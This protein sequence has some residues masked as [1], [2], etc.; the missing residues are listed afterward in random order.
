M[1]CF[2]LAE[3]GSRLRGIRHFQKYFGVFLCE[4]ILRGIGQ[5]SGL[6]AGDIR[7]TQELEHLKQRLAVMAEGHRALVGIALLHQHMAGGIDLPELLISLLQ[8]HT[9]RIRLRLLL[10]EGLLDE[11]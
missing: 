4:R 11:I 6:V 5:A 9:L 2:K 10:C 7:H 1:Q 3:T 8:R